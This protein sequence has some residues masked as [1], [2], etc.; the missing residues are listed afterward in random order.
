MKKPHPRSCVYCKDKWYHSAE[1]GE[2]NSDPSG[3]V[4]EGHKNHGVANLKSFPFR[5]EQPC[6]NTGGDDD[7]RRKENT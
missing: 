3:W 1:I 5:T 4:C 2:F 6:F 7:G